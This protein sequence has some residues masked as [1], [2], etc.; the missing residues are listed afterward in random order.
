MRVCVYTVNTEM[1]MRVCVQAECV[2]KQSVCASRV[3][4]QAEC[5]C[6]HKHAQVR[7]QT[8]KLYINL[9]GLLGRE[10]ELSAEPAELRRIRTRDP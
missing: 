10:A 4:V 1:H 9:W 3:C 8:R 2:C 5:V 6:K 7:T